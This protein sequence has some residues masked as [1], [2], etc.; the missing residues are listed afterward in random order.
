MNAW[1]QTAR[2][3][4]RCR[5]PNGSFVAGF[6]A[7]SCFYSHSPKL[8]AK[9]P[10]AK[11]GKGKVDEEEQEI[12]LP[13]M[14]DASRDMERKI[15]RLEVE[16]SK[17]RGGRA[18][19]DMLNFIRVEA[20]GDRIP[21]TD[22]AQISLKTP[23]K[24]VVQAYDAGIVPFVANAIRDADLGITPIVEGSVILVNVPK[25]SKEA[26]DALYKLVAKQGEQVT[27]NYFGEIL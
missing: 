21:I 11:G 19:A 20:Y 1:K 10:N 27:N 16:F 12:V 15:D 24:L 14:D 25:P 9:A 3:L 13:D 8:F 2:T 7:S 17:I 5:T 26:R 23:T 22:A 6:N 18:S 4:L